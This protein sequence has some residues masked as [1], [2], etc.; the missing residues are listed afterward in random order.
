[1]NNIA[2]TGLGHVEKI[3]ADVSDP[4]SL[5]AMARQCNIV[6]NTVG[7]YAKYGKTK[8]KY[9]HTPYFRVGISWCVN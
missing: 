7:P 1:M 4:D 8:E 6:L 2:G 9:S 5:E 3:N